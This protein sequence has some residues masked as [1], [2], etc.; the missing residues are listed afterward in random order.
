MF[1]KGNR[2]LGTRER[3]A[4]VEALNTVRGVRYASTLWASARRNGEYHGLNI[5]HL[6]GV[7]A[8]RDTRQRSEAWFDA[9]VKSLKADEGLSLASK[10]IDQIAVS[11]GGS[12]KTFL[13]AAQRGGVETYREPLSQ[14]PVWAACV[15]EWGRGSGFVAR[16]ARHLER[17][18]EQHGEAKETLENVVNGLWEKTVVAPMLRLAE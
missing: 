1:L 18:F 9:F 7:G 5:L 2:R 4:Y 11:A 17:W 10:S 16:V 15:A 3:L 8:A 13:E 12:R 14:A 6:V